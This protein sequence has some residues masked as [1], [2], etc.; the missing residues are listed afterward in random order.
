M[1]QTGPR[2]SSDTARKWLSNI[3]PPS[4][5]GSESPADPI[6]RNPKDVG[7]PGE[8]VQ[9]AEVRRRSELSAPPTGAALFSGPVAGYQSSQP[10]S[11]SMDRLVSILR[12]KWTI[13]ILWVL[14]SAPT[15]AVVW[16]QIVPQYAARAEVRVRPII[17]RLVFRTDDN[18]AI[19]FYDSFLNTQVSILRSPTLLQRVLEQPE[20]QKTQWYKDPPRALKDRVRRNATPAIE[21]LRDGLVTQPRP[22]TEIID[23]SFVDPSAKEAKL[24]VDTVLQQYMKYIGE[25]SSATENELDRELTAQYNNLQ[26]EIQSREKTCIDLCKALGT[27]EPQELISSERIR[28]NETQTRL[29]ELR[30]R[31]AALEWRIKRV[32]KDSNGVAAAS[33]NGT[34]RQSRYYEDEEWRRLDI[35][36]KRIEHQ[37]ATSIQGPNHPGRIRWVNEL[38]FAQELR[39]QRETQLDEIWQEQQKNVVVRS[40][41]PLPANSPSSGEEVMTAEQQLALAKHEEQLLQAGWEKQQ[42]EFKAQFDIAQSLERE[43]MELRHKRELYDA[44]R[45]RLDQKNIERNVPGTIS[46]SMWAYSPSQPAGDRRMVFTAMALFAGLG[47]GGGVAFLRASRNQTIYAPKDM[48]QPAQTPFLGLV[49]LVHLRK[50]LGKALCDEIEQ[51]QVLLT[52]AIRVL[53]TALLSRLNGQGCTTVVVTSA[54]EGTGKSSFTLVLGKSIAQAGRKVLMVDA[55]LH[56]ITLSKRLNLADKPGLRES[57]RDKTAESL[58]VFP[59]E[60]AGLD[61]MPAGQPSSGDVVFEEIANGAFRKAVRRL[62]EAHGYDII[63]LDT[64]PILPVADAAILAG[65]VDGAIMVEREHVSRRTEVA[66]ALIRLGTTGGRLLGTVFV[67][68]AE[69][70][71]YGYGCRYGRHYGY[72]DKE[73]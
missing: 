67:G 34:E 43:N 46:V 66:R 28:L 3:L 36:V 57:L 21:R 16:T 39:Q 41:M 19:P 27:N 58:H 24:I 4:E 69:Q 51:K 48:P 53:R 70:D 13:L 62:V 59:T 11:S 37:T 2:E 40:M 6:A 32:P 12:F 8:G 42:A 64:P 10:A 22:R 18:G 26:V 30:N 61:I 38:K 56:K 23:V 55:D 29:S 35:D 68:S 15:I 14:V 1:G 33:P 54:N 17:P 52:E 9:P 63:L 44:V 71:H 5:E 65:Q 31:I 45:Q 25:Q 73:S 47:M 72:K 20:I 50:P 49:P 60:T 7:K